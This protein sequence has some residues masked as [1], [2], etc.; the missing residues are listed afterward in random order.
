MRISGSRL[1]S[2]PLLLVNALLVT[3]FSGYVWQ[4][5]NAELA[6]PALPG[7]NFASHRA[8][9]L[10]I[11]YRKP[12]GCSCSSN[13]APAIR[14]GLSQKMNVIVVGTASELPDADTG[15]LEKDTNVRLISLPAGS[16]FPQQIAAAQTRT[17]LIRDGRIV[18]RIGGSV[19]TDAFFE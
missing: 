9:T 1:I 11:S 2:H 7:W 15:G 3:G 6:A 13:L 16:Q 19:L 12:S 10:L 18:H 17:F 14:Q 8:P 4:A 5:K